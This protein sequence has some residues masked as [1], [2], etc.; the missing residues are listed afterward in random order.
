MGGRTASRP[1]PGFRVTGRGWSGARG[2]LQHLDMSV[3]SPAPVGEAMTGAE[4]SHV[5]LEGA[6]PRWRGF[7]LPVITDE[8]DRD[9]RF[10]GLPGGLAVETGFGRNVRSRRSARTGLAPRLGHHSRLVSS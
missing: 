4:R 7:G 2:A 1:R 5:G 10:G 6:R 9:R 3:L 8:D